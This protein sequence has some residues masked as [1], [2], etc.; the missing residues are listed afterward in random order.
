MTVGNTP[1]LTSFNQQI[2]A[3]ALWLYQTIQQIAKKAAQYQQLAGTAALLSAIGITNATDQTNVLDFVGALAACV[4]FANGTFN[5]QSSNIQPV[6]VEF[7]G[8]Q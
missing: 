6:I 4:S 1:N 2:S 8:L 5:G 3:D 7:M